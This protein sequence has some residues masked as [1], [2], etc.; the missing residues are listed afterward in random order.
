M[1]LRPSGVLGHLTLVLSGCVPDSWTPP[2]RVDA[3]IADRPDASKS[4]A[5]DVAAEA[6]S[7]PLCE[8][9][10]DVLCAQG[11]AS[12]YRA[13]G[14][15]RD[16]AGDQHGV[17]RRGVTYAPGRYGT[18]FNIDGSPEYVS[19][20]SAVGDLEEEFTISLWLKTE[21]PGRFLVRRTACWGVPA[22]RGLDMGVQ[23][24]GH[25]NVEVFL[26]GNNTFFTLESPTSAFDGR[27]HHV[28]MVRRGAT[29]SL[30]VDGQSPGP[31]R[32]EA[33]FIDPYSTPVYLG[34]ST[35]VAGAPSGNGTFDDRPW[36]RGAID[37]VAFYRRALTDE[38]LGDIAAG[39]CAP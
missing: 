28:A 1:R 12:L 20:P 37:E 39:R 16:S 35:C 31:H 7:P 19:L 32:F 33:D 13:E 4:D 3:A 34:V 36:F 26:D 29:L 24:D 15:A 21:H 10:C 9:P 6:G 30:F 23:R 25:F 14:N 17:G 11:I 8:G 2:P 5:S 22:F 18:A 38:E 27:W